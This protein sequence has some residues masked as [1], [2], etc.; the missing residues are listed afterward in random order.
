MENSYYKNKYL[1]YKLKYVKEKEKID[2]RCKQIGG[3]LTYNCSKFYNNNNDYCF[4]T[5]YQFIDFLRILVKSSKWN[6]TVLAE[7]ANIDFDIDRYEELPELVKLV[8]NIKP[9]PAHILEMLLPIKTVDYLRK[10]LVGDVSTLT[11]VEY[12]TSVTIKQ[13]IN[14]DVLQACVE[15]LYL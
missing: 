9:K 4:Q 7:L 1:K 14:A 2:N 6:N 5:R 11:Y 12:L 15:I 3:I 13:S 8:L 10:L